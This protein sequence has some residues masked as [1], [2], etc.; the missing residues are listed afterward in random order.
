MFDNFSIKPLYKGSRLVSYD[1]I[2]VEYY[3]GSNDNYVVGVWVTKDTTVEDPF[4]YTPCEPYVMFLTVDSV[5]G[6][7]NYTNIVR[8]LCV[9]DYDW[10]RLFK[11][12]FH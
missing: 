5:Y 6:L 2:P 12:T 8:I 10:Y 7:E 9:S 3:D 4:T 1:N 11:S